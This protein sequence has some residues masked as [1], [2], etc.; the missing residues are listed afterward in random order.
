M[1]EEKNNS[2]S[3][4]DKIGDFK[5]HENITGNESSEMK[6]DNSIYNEIFKEMLY[7][8]NSRNIKY[9]IKYCLVKLSIK[10]IEDIMSVVNFS[11]KKKILIK[12][13]DILFYKLRKSKL[14]R[15]AKPGNYL[16]LFFDANIENFN[17]VFNEV[18]K[19]ANKEFGDKF[20]LQWDIIKTTEK[21]DELK[22]LLNESELITK[23]I[24]KNQ[25]KKYPGISIDRHPSDSDVVVV[26]SVGIK[27]M[28]KYFIISY[29]IFFSII[30]V[31]GVII[32][33]AEQKFSFIPAGL[34]FN[35][36]LAGLHLGFLNYFNS[37]FATIIFF[38]I[39]SL[40]FSVV[41]GL[42]GMLIGWIMNI[43]L[44]VSG[45]ID[46]KLRD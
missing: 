15:L 7:L 29:L 35:E 18:E 33:F 21:E 39:A 10:N 13:S 36:I 1:E 31:I 41:F 28:F 37:Q 38:I 45:G 12:F 8:E 23:V 3:I 19:L 43:S 44:R 6:E 9:R 14:F 32:Y 46:V 24:D 26:R 2:D 34:K 42:I 17:L 30:I 40:A 11:D 4:K 27:S 20:K 25:L 16:I 5:E 22:P